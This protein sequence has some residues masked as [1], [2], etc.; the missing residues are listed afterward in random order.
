M[1]LSPS[2]EVQSVIH[3]QHFTPGSHTVEVCPALHKVLCLHINMG[4]VPAQC[5]RTGAEISVFGEW[6]RDS[7][8]KDFPFK[9][10]SSSLAPGS[11]GAW[12]AFWIPDPSVPSE[13]RAGSSRQ[14]G[15]SKCQRERRK[16]KF[17][18]C[19]RNKGKGVFFVCLFGW[20]YL[21]CFYYKRLLHMQNSSYSGIY[22]DAVKYRE[23]I[24]SR[25]RHSVWNAA[26]LVIPFVRNVEADA[27]NLYSHLSLISWAS[28]V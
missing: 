13:K 25:L 12:Y 15:I 6:G 28:G 20:Q 17:S 26:G 4:I 2:Q 11:W 3:L 9:D 16:M 8:L 19:A 14:Q 10:I 5:S 21:S 24:A 27:V 23:M 7:L 1:A 18:I 22:G